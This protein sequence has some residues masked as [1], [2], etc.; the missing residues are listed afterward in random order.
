MSERR[1]TSSR[2][3]TTKFIPRENV[4]WREPPSGLESFRIESPDVVGE[5][6]REWRESQRNLSDEA[7]VQRVL[8]ET[9]GGVEVPD[10]YIWQSTLTQEL[11]SI[12]PEGAKHERGM[13]GPPPPLFVSAKEGIP[14]EEM[15]IPKRIYAGGLVWEV[16]AELGRGANGR[17]HEVRHAGEHQRPR[18]VKIMAMRATDPNIDHLRGS[19]WNEVGAS[20]AAGDY[21]TDEILYDEEGNI[22]TAIILERHEGK[23]LQ[24]VI[25]E[26]QE[27]S[28]GKEQLETPQW[29]FKQAM[30]LRAVVS[31]LRRMHAIGWTHRDIKPANLIANM[32][33]GEESLSRPIDYGSA[34][35]DGVIRRK[36]SSTIIGTTNFMPPEVSLSEDT[37]LRMRDYWAAVLSTG[38]ATGLFVA[39]QVKSPH[40]VFSNLLQGEHIQAPDLASPR[41]ADTYFA[42]KHMLGAQRNFLE[43]LYQF[44]QPH[45]SMERR[46]HQWR[47][48]GIT[49]TLD[50]PPVDPISLILFPGEEVFPVSSGDFIDDD[51][52]VRELEDHIRALAAQTGIEVPD[53]ILADL[54]EFPLQQTSEDRILET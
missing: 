3:E 42:E 28:E 1:G 27:R 19:L 32:E 15:A 2:Q 33:D 53:Q 48:S 40:R 41:H 30:A 12:P 52:F 8:R 47:L 54:Q 43:W 13:D 16:G 29:A 14:A 50:I 31:R 26:A 9:E 46:Q 6:A 10:G 38:M 18:L 35:H 22:W 36:V 37:D 45:M 5:E 49:Q 11:A 34:V 21:T 44:I 25:R 51:K 7:W 39:A 24:S 4:P 20:M 17:V 23:T